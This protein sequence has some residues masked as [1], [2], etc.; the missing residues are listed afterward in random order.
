M[1]ERKIYGVHELGLGNSAPHPD[2]AWTIN[3]LYEDGSKWAHAFPTTTLWARS[4]EY[5]IPIGEVDTLI[6]VILYE[7]V[8]MQLG[9]HIDHNHPE[10]LYNTDED[11]ARTSH[12]NRIERT[13]LLVSHVDPSGHLDTLREY[14]AGS[15]GK[16]THLDYYHS[17]RKLVGS[18][19]GQKMKEL[20]RT[21]R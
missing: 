14:H 15:I 9:L 16:K 7:R 21:A 1:K 17:H 10:F 12:L 18:L 3:V 8:M 20:E 19:R 13:K 4:A 2:L 11:T 6:D 5:G